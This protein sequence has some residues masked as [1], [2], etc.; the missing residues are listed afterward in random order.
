MNEK[1]IST[2]YIAEQLNYTYMAIHHYETGRTIPNVCVAIKI[3]NV[4]GVGV[5]EI[6]EVNTDDK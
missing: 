4:L 2:R 5:E 1:G 3:A 6:W